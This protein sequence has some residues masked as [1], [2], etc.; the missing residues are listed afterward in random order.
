M[1]VSMRPLFVVSKGVTDCNSQKSGVNFLQWSSLAWSKKDKDKRRKIWIWDRIQI[2]LAAA[3]MNHCFSNNLSVI[4][5]YRSECADEPVF[6]WISIYNYVNVLLIVQGRRRMV[7]RVIKWQ[8]RFCRSVNPIQSLKVNQGGGILCP[9]H[10]QSLRFN[11]G[12]VGG[13]IVPVTLLLA[14][15]FVD[16]PTALGGMVLEDLHFTIDE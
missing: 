13:Q 11:Q 8:C 3:V 1:G 9:S 7:G 4:L 5:C 16:L 10:I 2:V 12:G 6:I 14:P 15:V